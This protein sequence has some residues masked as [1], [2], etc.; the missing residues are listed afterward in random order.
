MKK[1]QAF[2]FEIQP[3][4]EQRRKML[5]FAGSSRFVFNKALA[6]QNEQYAK[7]S[8]F[9]F[10]YA[11]L[12][13]LL[14]EWKKDPALLWLKECPSQ[15][16]QQALKNLESSFRNF[17]A[18]RADFPKFKKKGMGDSFRFPQGFKLDQGNCRLFLPKLG[19]IRYRKSREI[20]GVP[21]NIT[22]SLK[23]GQWYVAIQ[24]E[25]EQETCSHSASSIVGI[26]VGITRFATLSDGAYIEPLNSFKKHQKSLAKYQRRMSRKL[27]FSQNW[28]KAKA[29]VTQLHTKIAHARS[30]FL[31]K[32]STEI[33][34]NHA[35][36]CI[37]DVR[38][39]NMS[40]SAKGNSEIHGKKV[41]Q[42]SG[43]NRSILDQGWGEFRRQLEYK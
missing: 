17:F 37:E 21:K 8:T 22:V 41:R 31:H 6:W 29:K 13:N 24:T 34:K 32:T 26:D 23:S 35:I 12:A 15:A 19:W 25:Q 18:Q 5:K 11:T 38:I 16:L 10:S 4:G 9:E 36:I 42:K 7:D 40:K 30:D 20:V 27:K 1:R 14:P 39:G 43:L 2:K 3:N 28:K 33:S